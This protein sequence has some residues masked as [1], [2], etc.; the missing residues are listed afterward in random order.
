[1]FLDFQDVE[2]SFAGATFVACAKGSDVVVR[3]R[4]ALDETHVATVAVC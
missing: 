2:L 4:L 1:V 3:G